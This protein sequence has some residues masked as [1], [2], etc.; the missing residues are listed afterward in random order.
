[1]ECKKSIL[2]HSK[3]YTKPR[4]HKVKDGYIQPHENKRQM[5]GEKN[6]H[7]MKTNKV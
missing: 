7:K 4:S 5:H 2:S 1:M 6:H 3:N